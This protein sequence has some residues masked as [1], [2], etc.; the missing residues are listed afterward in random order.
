MK[1]EVEGLP[2]KPGVGGDQGQ[3]KPTKGTE[4][5]PGLCTKT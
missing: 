1:E 3:E 2:H 5:T 4:G